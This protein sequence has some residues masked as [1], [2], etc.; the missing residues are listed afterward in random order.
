VRAGKLVALKVADLHSDREMFVVWDR[1][2][3]LSA[4]ARTFRLFL[5]TNPVPDPA[6]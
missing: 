5:E 3:V 2:R 1:R 6:P 4:P